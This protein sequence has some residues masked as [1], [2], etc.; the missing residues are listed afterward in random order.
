MFLV[1]IKDQRLL[2][3]DDRL[4]KSKIL[5]LEVGSRSR[6]LLEVKIPLIFSK[7]SFEGG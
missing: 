4:E 5:R 1:F 7:N 3:V 6:N 2:G